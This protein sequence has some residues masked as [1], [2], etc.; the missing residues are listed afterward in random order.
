MLRSSFLLL[1]MYDLVGRW[2]PGYGVGADIKTR[3]YRSTI[4]MI[5]YL[6]ICFCTSSCG[7][8]DRSPGLLYVPLLMLARSYMFI[9]QEY[10]VHDTKE[11][12]FKRASFRFRYLI[13]PSPSLLHTPPFH[14][15]IC[16]YQWE[17][18]KAEEKARQRPPRL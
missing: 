1:C 8:K 6:V 15:P 9:T 4:K 16:H 13:L 14:R 18:I 5:G 2:R 12:L 17:A 3:L 7:M 10:I 11:S